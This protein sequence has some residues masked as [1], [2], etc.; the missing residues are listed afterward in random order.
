MLLLHKKKM[1]VGATP[2]SYHFAC[3]ATP[4]SPATFVANVMR[5]IPPSFSPIPVDISDIYGSTDDFV[6]INHCNV[7]IRSGAIASNIY[8]DGVSL[9]SQAKKFMTCSCRV[10]YVV[11]K[12]I[13]TAY[14]HIATGINEPVSV[15]MQLSEEIEEV[16]ARP[17]FNL[18]SLQ[19]KR[20]L[21]RRAFFLAKRFY[22]VSGSGTRYVRNLDFGGDADLCTTSSIGEI[23]VSGSPRSIQSAYHQV[24]LYAV[25]CALQADFYVDTVV[26]STIHFATGRVFSYT[27]QPWMYID[28]CMVKVD[29]YRNQ[30]HWMGSGRG[31]Q[32]D[33]IQRCKLMLKSGNKGKYVK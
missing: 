19:D 5:P 4:L 33:M 24:L 28:N 23:K 31:P 32:F 10:G 30:D 2:S 20:S 25:R 17:A 26:I 9:S 22:T 13:R 27:V 8:R 15:D 14:E 1:S 12:W 29:L 7:K 6:S 3:Q 11:E 18:L 21:L 16:S